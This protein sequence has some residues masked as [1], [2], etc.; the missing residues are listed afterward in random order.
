[1]WVGENSNLDRLVARATAVPR[2]AE[3]ARQTRHA[4]GARLMAADQYVLPCVPSL[5]RRLCRPRH[6]GGACYERSTLASGP[7]PRRSLGS[8]LW[9]VRERVERYLLLAIA[10]AAAERGI[11][12]HH[13]QPLVALGLRQLVL[14]GEELLL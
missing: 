11:Q 2:P 10:P 5:S 4:R 1:S 13:G 3:L 14:G 9:P 6:A 8:A 12:L 7:D